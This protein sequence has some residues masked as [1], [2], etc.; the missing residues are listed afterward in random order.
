MFRMT[1]RKFL[2]A[3]KI[4]IWCITLKCIMTTRRTTRKGPSWMNKASTVLQMSVLRWERR[5]GAA[6]ECSSG[7]AVIT[8]EKW[9]AQ[10]HSISSGQI[11]RWLLS[12]KSSNVF[13]FRDS[14]TEEKTGAA[15]KMLSF[16]LGVTRMEPY[17]YSQVC[18]QSAG[19]KIR[20]VI[21]YMSLNPTVQTN[22][23]AEVHLQ[24]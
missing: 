12:G 21:S 11:D 17:S 2:M 16:P 5:E 13:W 20:L 8:V 22:I 19:N 23:V 3:K 9:T 14:G 7:D 4:S 1:T 15:I 18:A 24:V 10:L 6:S